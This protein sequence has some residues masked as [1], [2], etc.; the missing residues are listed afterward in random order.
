MHTAEPIL[1]EPS[2]FEA[3]ITI[4]NLKRYKSPGIDQIPTELIQGGS[5]VLRSE[6]HKIIVCISKK[7]ELPRQWKESIVV[8]IH[9]RGD[10]IEYSSYRGI[11]LLLTTDNI[12]FQG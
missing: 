7:E 1:L 4:E 11:S 9:R 2:T 5:N 10:K 8:S 12:L 6:I 3:G